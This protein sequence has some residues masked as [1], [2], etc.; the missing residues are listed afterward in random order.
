MAESGS[1]SKHP[2]QDKPLSSFFQTLEKERDDEPDF[3]LAEVTELIR[4]DR[5]ASS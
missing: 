2:D 1:T 3:T 5:D 4:K